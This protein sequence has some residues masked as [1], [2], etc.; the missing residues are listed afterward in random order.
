M[1]ITR[2]QTRGQVTLPSEARRRAGIKPGD[3]VRI[4][5]VGPGEI[6]LRALPSLSPRAL[7]ERYP[8]EGPIDIPRDREAWYDDAARD[9]LGR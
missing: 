6:R 9:V 3:A 1:R 7:R 8:I 2:V 4:E 5:A